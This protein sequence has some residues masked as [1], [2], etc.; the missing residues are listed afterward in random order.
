MPVCAVDLT[1]TGAL[2]WWLDREARPWSEIEAL[3]DEL[4]PDH[5][6]VLAS[7]V[8]EGVRVVGGAPRAPSA[9]IAVS[10]VRAARTLEDLVLVDAPLVSEAL[11]DAIAPLA[12]RTLVLAYDDPVSRRVLE[13]ATEDDAWL[14][15]SQTRVERLAGREVF[16]ALPRDEA[17]VASALDRRG[18]VGGALG[19]AYDELADLLVLDA[20]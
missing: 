2:G 17:S 16:R 4:S 10:A 7:E 19:R 18:A 9:A 12:D 6:V 11:C 8:R 3:G 1:G 14:V 15:V 5:L 20:S 13:A